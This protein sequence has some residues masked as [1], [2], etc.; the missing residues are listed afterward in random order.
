MMSEVRA[1]TNSPLRIALI[2]YYLP[3]ESKIGVGYWVHSYANAL[4][5][6]GHQVTVLSPCARPD[7]ALYDVER[8][9]LSGANRTF[10][11]ALAM[12]HVDWSR[13]DVLH[14]NGDDYWL[15]KRRVPVHIRTMHGSCFSEA[16]HIK[17]IKERARM[18]AL[19]VGELLATL[20]ADQTACVS[21]ETRR[22]MPWVRTVIPVGVDL[23]RFTPASEKEPAPTILFVGTYHQRK[24]GKLLMEVFQD[25]VRPAVPD[26]RLWM[27]C[28]DA[29]SAPGVEV[30]GRLSNEELVRRYQRA[31]IFCLPSSYEGLG[32]P[33]IEAMA[34][35]LPVVATP[36]PGS[37]FVLGGGAHG[38]LARS[39]DLGQRVAEL[40]TDARLRADMSHRSL[41]RARDL[42]LD[43]VL[44]AYEVLYADGDSGR[45]TWTW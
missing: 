44:R 35:G 10:K 21:P 20:V 34:C 36:N 14:A 6:R 19:G 8:V 32:V 43:A 30:L 38:A 11:F 45:H 5:E 33:Y 13:F 22:W 18:L 25:E 3:S 28:S 2:S 26:A 42:S 39:S 24:R 23:R 9:A 37:R 16:L 17:G 41:M 31:W 27:V 15:W 7:D 1:K 40:L 12:R 4:V 29:P